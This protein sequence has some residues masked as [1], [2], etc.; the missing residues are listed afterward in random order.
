MEKEEIIKKWQIMISNIY[1][2]SGDRGRSILKMIHEEELL[3]IINTR[4]KVVI[5]E[6]V[7]SQDIKEIKELVNKLVIQEN[8]LNSADKGIVGEKYIREILESTY[9]V[10]DVHGETAKGDFW[11]DDI[12]IEVKNWTRP[13]QKGEISKFE[14]DI[15]QT[16]KKGGL[17]ISLNTRIQGM[18]IF[19][20]MDIITDHGHKPVIYVTTTD[21][22]IIIS[23]LEIIKLEIELRERNVRIEDEEIKKMI[24]EICELDNINDRLYPMI[25]SLKEQIS[26]IYKNIMDLEIKSKSIH[27]EHKEKINEIKKRMNVIVQTSHAKTEDKKEDNT[28]DNTAD[29]KDVKKPRGRRAIKK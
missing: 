1:E 14:R 24:K 22:D 17:F 9:K 3:E 12:V 20:K 23:A 16:G 11:I 18:G 6:E 4:T 25:S 5:R 2:N 19:N 15:R 7:Q 29:K 10:K 26:I 8:K 28:E 27:N 21:S 13:V